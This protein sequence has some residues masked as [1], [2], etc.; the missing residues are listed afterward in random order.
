MPIVLDHTIIPAK[1]KLA[2]AKFFAEIFGLS[3]KPGEGHFAQVRV[4][5]TLTFDFADELE[6]QSHHYAFHISEAEFEAILGRV[7]VKKSPTA[8]RHTITPMVRSIL[9]AADGAFTSR[10]LTAT[11]WK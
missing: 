3:I 8:A 9:A 5:N 11:C 1:D 7:K 4:N 2:A 6:P 10:I